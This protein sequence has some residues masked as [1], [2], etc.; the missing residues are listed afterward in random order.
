V[1]KTE[2]QQ[3]RRKGSGLLVFSR[4]FGLKGVWSSSNSPVIGRKEL[5]KA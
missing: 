1:T 4:G 3:Q 2:K 5:L